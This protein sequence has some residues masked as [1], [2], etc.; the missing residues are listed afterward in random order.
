LEDVARHAYLQRR[1]PD[2][3]WEV[4]MTANEACLHNPG[5]SPR[6]Y[7]VTRPGLPEGS[8]LVADGE[9]GPGQLSVEVPAEGTALVRVALDGAAAPLADGARRCPIDSARPGARR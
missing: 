8:A 1:R 2:A 6:E 5:P 7:T 9:A 4:L 3:G